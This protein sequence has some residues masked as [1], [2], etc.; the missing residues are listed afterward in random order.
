MRGKRRRTNLPGAALVGM[1][2]QWSTWVQ[3]GLKGSK[4]VCTPI[5]TDQ[6]GDESELMIGRDRFP[7]RGPYGLP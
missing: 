6:D 2:L 4:M 5:P 3:N 7:H 1:G